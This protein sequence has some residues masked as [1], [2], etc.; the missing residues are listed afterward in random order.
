MTGTEIS[1][2]N[3][4]ITLE[5]V[6][7]GFDIFGFHI[8]FYGLIIALGM[9]AGFMV[10]SYQAKKTGQSTE[11]YLDFALYAIVCAVIGARI[12][13]VIFSWD[14]YKNN[15]IEIFNIRGGGL[16]IY[17]GVIG[18]I[19]TAIIFS[20]V[21][22]V[23]FA[24]LADTACLGLITGQIIGRWGNFFNTEAF[25]S[26]AGNTLFAMKLPWE[27]AVLHMS[28]KS[29][30][31]LSAYVVDG[32]ILVHP[33]F[34]Y[35]SFWNLCVLIFL[36][37]Y[38]NR[39]KF[40]GEVILLYLFFY[41]LGRSWIEGLRTDQLLLWGTQIPVSQGL[42]VIMAIGSAIAIVILRTKK[43]RFQEKN[44]VYKL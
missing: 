38:S 19:I 7:S 10:A 37:W 34:L 29:A 8:A 26:Y 33:T 42:A 4:G 13:Y 9:M 1:F 43:K 31:Q 22:K 39:K 23:K 16:A 36:L 17:G 6:R 44:S 25:G 11:M 41:G 12:Y 18:G 14:E 2:P 32:T 28:P 20:K 30:E 5:N 21:R 40:D 3:L 24:L 35:E 15:P 27:K